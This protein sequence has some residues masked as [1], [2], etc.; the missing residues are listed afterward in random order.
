[1]SRGGKKRKKRQEQKLTTR[2]QELYN[3]DPEDGKNEKLIK[4]LEALHGIGADVL[5]PEHR[6]V[7]SFKLHGYEIVD[8]ALNAEEYEILSYELC[9]AMWKKAGERF[10]GYRPERKWRGIAVENW[11]IA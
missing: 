5:S 1:M 9:Q 2:I 11:M 6:G 4:K 7:D 8:Q 3:L 10:L